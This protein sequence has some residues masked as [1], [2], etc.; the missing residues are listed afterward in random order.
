M[1]RMYQYKHRKSLYSIWYI[2]NYL[3]VP[4]TIRND[5]DVRRELVETSSETHQSVNIIPL[6][7]K[8]ISNATYTENRHSMIHEY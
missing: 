4:E 3:R 2:G 7:Q 1:I 5:Y 8:C 6:M